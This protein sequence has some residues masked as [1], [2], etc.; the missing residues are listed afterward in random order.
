MAPPSPREGSANCLVAASPQ[1]QRTPFRGQRIQSV[2]ITNEVCLVAGQLQEVLR[3]FTES[4]R[5]RGSKGLSPMKSYFLSLLIALLAVTAQAQRRNKKPT[6]EE[7]IKKLVLKP[8][9]DEGGYYRQTYKSDVGLPANI[10]GI[11]SDLMRHISTA[12]YFLETTDGFSAL[13]R[14]KSDEVYHF[15]AGDPVEMIQID[16]SG[17]LS[18]FVLGSDILNNQSPQVVAPK[19]IWQA[20]KLMA[21]GRWALMGT[22]VAPGFEFEDFELADRNQML[23]QFPQLSQY[24]L[25]YTRPKQS[26]QGESR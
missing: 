22:T 5:R 14:I 13:H 8:L 1:L 17:A 12:I 10:F 3:R 19:G 21:G 15:Y 6:A 18:R 20:S 11:R 23:K 26:R 25:N 4:V 2:T 16:N 24:V 7:V 9:P